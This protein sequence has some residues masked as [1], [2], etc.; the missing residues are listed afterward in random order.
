MTRPSES[1]YAQLV[2]YGLAAAQPWQGMLPIC[3]SC[4]RIRNTEHAWQAGEA[5]IAAHAPVQCTHSDGGMTQ[6]TGCSHGWST[7]ALGCLSHGW[8]RP[9]HEQFS[10]QVQEGC[11]R[12]PHTKGE[13]HG[14]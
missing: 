8:P 4:K 7:W 13:T 11:S 2:E 14:A 9:Q 1:I 12:T 3:A 6:S 10:R 5:Y